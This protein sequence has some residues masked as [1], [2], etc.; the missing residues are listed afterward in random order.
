MHGGVTF[1]KAREIVIDKMENLC[2]ASNP[3]VN[4]NC[5]EIMFGHID[6]L[7]YL[8]ISP[9]IS[10]ILLLVVASLENMFLTGLVVTLTLVF[11]MMGMNII[12]T[13]LYLYTEKS[14]VHNEVV[15]II[16]NYVQYISSFEEMSL[17]EENSTRPLYSGHSQI[18]I[19]SVFRN[20]SW[21]RL[22]TLL[23]V[24]GDIIALS[25]GDLTPGC[26]YELISYLDTTLEGNPSTQPPTTEQTR[27][28][29]SSRRGGGWVRGRS[30]EAGV[31]IHLRQERKKY[32]Y[33]PTSSSQ[34]HGNRANVTNDRHKHNRAIHSESTELLV[35]SGDMRCYLMRETPMEKFLSSVL[36]N[37]GAG[38]HE[39]GDGPPPPL[40]GT[41]QAKREANNYVKN[42]IIRKLFNVC[43]SLCIGNLK[44]SDYSLL[45]YILDWQ[46][47]IS[48]GVKAMLVMLGLVIIASSDRK[49]VV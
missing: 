10:F 20:N 40:P 27:Y 22:P 34:S 1:L 25:A 19:V 49:S 42:N 11:L 28:N 43:I 37:G 16:N 23:L 47:M 7:L 4:F 13:Y 39:D 35:L 31:K 48:E 14:E 44:K 18:S 29:H 26:V 12:I 36:E 32:S 33:A 46:V 5:L 24:E 21:H 6:Y 9:S 41:K 17:S 2:K 8:V 45:K 3:V 30:F 38:L 15:R